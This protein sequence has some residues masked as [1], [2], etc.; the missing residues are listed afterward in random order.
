[1]S[2]LFVIL[3]SDQGYRYELLKNVITIGRDP[4]NIIRLKD[5]ETSRFHAEIQ[6]TDSGDSLKDLGSSN[7]VFLNAKRVE[8]PQTLQNGDQI[9][10]GRTL[11]L[12]TRPLGSRNPPAHDTSAPKVVFDR[13]EEIQPPVRILHSMKQEEKSSVFEESRSSELLWRSKTQSHLQMMYH[14]TLVVS[15][16]LDIDRL[17]QRIME[18]IFEWVHVDRGCVFLYDSEG[19]ELHPKVTKT[20]HQ[21]PPHVRMNISRRIFE[22]VL[23]KQEGV[24]TSDAQKDDRWTADGSILYIGI[25]E[26]ICVPMRGRYGIVGVIYIDT[27]TSPQDSVHL[28][29]DG[30]KHLTQDHLKL[31]IA[32]AHQAALAVEDTRYYLGMVQAERLAA[33]GQTVAVLSHHIKNILQGIKSG[34]YLIEKGLQDTNLEMAGKGWQIVEKNQNRISDLVLDMLTFSKDREPHFVR[35][36]INRVVGDVFELM[37]GRA[38]ELETTLS[39]RFDETIPEFPFDAEQIHRAVTNV[40]TNAIDAAS[41]LTGEKPDRHTPQVEIH[42]EWNAESRNVRIVVDDNGPGV[43]PENIDTLF[44]PFLSGKQGK[45]TGLGLAVTQKIIL[46]HKGGITVEKSPGGGARFVVELP[47]PAA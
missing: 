8:T 3:G 32:I 44:R 47:M 20:R 36:R 13:D 24:L 1:M 25:R 2:S 4:S 28:R 6:R 21:V 9:Q 7:G 40:V 23:Q 16:T 12:Y 30:T 14:T 35:D 5:G 41:Y 43:P 31:M 22:Y 33:V 45:G 10:I 11:F 37:S 26:A 17:L 27:T 46:E 18:L 42:T 34:S 39:G 38:R 15:Q 29:P 19:K